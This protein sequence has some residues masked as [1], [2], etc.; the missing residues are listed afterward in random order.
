MRDNA[1][2]M[3]ETFKTRAQTMPAMNAAENMKSYAGISARHARGMENLVPAFATLYDT[4]S[5]GQK[6]IADQVFRDN[7]DRSH[8]GQG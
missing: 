2:D 7:A 6:H 1:R 5:D 8:R 4:M 3:D